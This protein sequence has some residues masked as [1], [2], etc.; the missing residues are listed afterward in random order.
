MLAK[1]LGLLTSSAP[2]TAG[3]FA[4]QTPE[5]DP[6]RLLAEARRELRALQSELEPL[7]Q[8][9]TAAEA[10]RH[11]VLTVI[12]DAEQAGAAYQAA[13]AAC[14]QAAREWAA[15]G[16]DPAEPRIPEELL[17]AKD[18]HYTIHHDARVAAEGARQALPGLEQAVSA[19]E[20]ALRSAQ[21][22]IRPAV[23]G[24]LTAMIEPHLQRIER[25]H[26]A[27]VEALDPVRSLD[28]VL[29]SW[30]PAHPFA[31]FSDP[32]RRAEIGARLAACTLPAPPRTEDVN[33][34]LWADSAL[35]HDAREWLD[36][37]RRLVED[38]EATL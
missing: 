26:T 37:A 13:H 11:R 16:A 35:R 20:E 17:E 14:E 29:R 12:E 3:A 9:L 4:A 1:I 28:A 10:R 8:A 30:G 5:V 24:V 18:R 2:S 19:A 31:D 36:L 22:L 38:P 15:R 32:T 21:D 33:K 25:A 7:R 23:C 27:Y 6:N 34:A